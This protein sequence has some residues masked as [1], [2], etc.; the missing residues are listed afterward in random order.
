[1][2]QSWIDPESGNETRK[3]KC[4]G[5]IFSLLAALPAALADTP[6]NCSYE[7]IAGTWIF[8]VGPSG[9]DNTLD[10]RSG[11][12]VRGSLTVKLSY[13]DIVTDQD[14]NKGFWTMIYNQGFEVVVAGRKYFAF[15]MYEARNKS[16]TSYCNSTFDGWSHDLNG[17]DWACY[18]GAKQDSVR[19]SH[20]SIFGGDVMDIKYRKDLDFINEINSKTDLW[21]AAHYPELEGRTLRERLL[22]AG[23]IPKPGGHVYPKI[24]PITEKDLDAVRDLPES[25]DWRNQNGTSFVSPIRDQGHCGSCYAF[26]S[27][28]MLEARIRMMSNNSMQ[29][30]LSTQDIVSCSEYS[31]ACNEMLMQAELI[32]NGPISVSFE[33]TE[34][35]E[36][37]K[38]GIYH[39]VDVGD[40]F[41][42][43]EVTNHVVSIVGGE[44]GQVLDSE[45]QLG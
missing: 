21:E 29:P 39:K 37:Y 34:D 38:N 25:F 24:A 30:V 14:G 32:K 44:W 11:F 19:P 6:A 1:M 13:P 28:A 22:R 45:E 4:F 18:F 12:Q 2:M 23:G 31:Q 5:V 43:W 9:Q 36:A 27:M 26:G 41:N 10:C 42:P 8:H 35:F 33:V 3:M 15:S 7:S 20:G 40:G 17:E 16:V